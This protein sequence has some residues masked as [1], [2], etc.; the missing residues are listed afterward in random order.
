MDRKF[1]VPPFLSGRLVS[2]K[3]SDGGSDA[4]A[5][6][7]LGVFGVPRLRGRELRIG[8][9]AVNRSEKTGISPL[10]LA[11]MPV[12]FRQAIR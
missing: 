9:W 8:S 10:T 2:P 12:G 4:K 7:G 5:E 1:G 6:G 3:Q 11:I